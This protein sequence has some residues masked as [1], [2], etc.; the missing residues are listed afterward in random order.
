MRLAGMLYKR[1]LAT[2]DARTRPEHA[3]ADGQTV[4]AHAPFS[5]GGSAMSYPGDPNAP[6]D[7]VVNCRC[8]VIAADG[9]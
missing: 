1:W 7:L 6:A 8:T 5:V 4:P 3:D 2:E 9:P